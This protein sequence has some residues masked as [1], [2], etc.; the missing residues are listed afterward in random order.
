MEVARAAVALDPSEKS[1]GHIYFAWGFA[2][3]MNEAWIARA[4]M[5]RMGGRGKCSE[6]PDVTSPQLR[7]GGAVDAPGPIDPGGLTLAGP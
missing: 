4:V 7:T 3:P 2:V 6:R 1:S 5:A